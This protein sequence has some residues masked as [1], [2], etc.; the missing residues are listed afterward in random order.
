MIRAL[1]DTVSYWTELKRYCVFYAGDEIILRADNDA[2]AIKEGAG[3]IAE[4]EAFYNG[5]QK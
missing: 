3:V 2:D 1:N 4:M 5:T